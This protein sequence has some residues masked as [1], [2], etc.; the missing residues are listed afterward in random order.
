MVTGGLMVGCSRNSGCINR[1]RREPRTVMCN[2]ILSIGLG[3]GGS[4]IGKSKLSNQAIMTTI[5]WLIFAI[6]LVKVIANPIFANWFGVAT[7][8]QNDSGIKLYEQIFR[9]ISFSNLIL[10]P[11]IFIILFK[12]IC[13]LLYRIVE[14][15]GNKNN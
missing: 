6:I 10:L 1:A 9:I 12:Y 14:S 2:S 5:F 11:I 3:Q 13:E 15:I 8:L 4:M 7:L